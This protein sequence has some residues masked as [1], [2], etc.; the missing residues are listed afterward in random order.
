MRILK[1]IAISLFI[2]FIYALYSNY[3]SSPNYSFELINP[4]SK[5]YEVKRTTEKVM[6]TPLTVLIDRRFNEILYLVDK[7]QLGELENALARYSATA[8]ALLEI[9][10]EKRGLKNLETYK[11]ELARIRDVFPANSSFWLMV[12]SSLDTTNR[13]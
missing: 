8:G 7:N 6:L 12:Q 5:F 10:K 4:D 3:S 2:L 11:S 1:T 13:L 9:P